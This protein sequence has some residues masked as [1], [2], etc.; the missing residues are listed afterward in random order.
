MAGA[1]RKG[2]KGSR[3]RKAAGRTCAWPGCD[4]DVGQSAAGGRPRKW[5]SSH[6]SPANRR[7]D[8]ALAAANGDPERAQ[9]IL[10]TLGGGG[11]APLPP[12]LKAACLAVGLWVHPAREVAA[13]VARIE[14]RGRDLLKLER[15]ARKHWPHVIEDPVSHL[16][17]LTSAFM[18]VNALHALSDAAQVPAAQRAQANQRA[19]QTIAQL[20]DA[21]AASYAGPVRVEWIEEDAA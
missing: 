11:G 18:C 4:R 16:P 12:T 17:R 10:A 19:A 13:E 2:S 5:C 15:L 7:R 21:S 20:H 6:S 8:A 9:Q 1:P 14:E 3:S